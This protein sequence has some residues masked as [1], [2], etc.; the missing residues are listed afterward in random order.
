MPTY[1]LSRYYEDM[2]KYFVENVDLKRL[3]LLRPGHAPASVL[4]AIGQIVQINAIRFPTLVILAQE[5]T[6]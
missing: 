4:S 1:Y 5:K 2:N 3:G 6:T